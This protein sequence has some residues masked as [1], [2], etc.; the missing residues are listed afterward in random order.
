MSIEHRHIEV[1]RAIMRSG[2]VTGAANQ[3]YT[4]QPTVSREL[5][6]LEQLLGFHLF[7]RVK[8][9]LHPTA[10]A[11][12][13]HEEIQRSYQSLEHII[14]T[15]QSLR[16]FAAGQ[17]SIVC[18]PALAQALVP[19]SC[20]RFKD[21][22]SSVCITLTPQ[23]S[24]QLE[25][26]L[27]AQRYDLGLTEHDI[28]PPGTRLET[29]LQADE[30]CVLPEGHP[31]L[32]KTTL[33]PADFDG[34][35][36]ISLSPQDPYRTEIDALFRTHGVSRIQAAETQSAAS[37]CCL[38]REGLGLA[39]VNPLTAL[40]YAGRGL[41]WRS[42]SVSIPFRVSLVHPSYRPSTPLTDDFASALQAEAYTIQHRLSRPQAD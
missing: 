24:P 17:L 1:F 11:V 21:Q 4:S 22:H 18:L 10:R 33:T 9:R 40:E 3:L 28:A 7:D 42:L 13:L 2:S 36:F 5:A 32:G 20:R 25:E 26:W 6:R 14:G 35:A 39:I 15:A 27:S 30:V 8:G 34:Q 29:L 37:A 23:E 41:H 38:A 16:E 12:L 31:L 19:A